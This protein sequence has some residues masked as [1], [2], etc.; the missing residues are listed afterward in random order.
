MRRAA[1]AA[2]LIAATPPSSMAVVTT[3]GYFECSDRNALQGIAIDARLVAI[4]LYFQGLIQGVT[5]KQRKA[6]YASK[7]LA[8]DKFLVINK[9]RELI[10]SQCISID[11]AVGAVARD[12]CP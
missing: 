7:V 1:L 5:D 11:A 2:L 3:S 9:T 6:C 8:D 4:K 12:L 10:E